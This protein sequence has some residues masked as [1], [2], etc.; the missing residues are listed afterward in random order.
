MAKEEVI[1]RNPLAVKGWKCSLQTD[2]DQE[3]VSIKI[4]DVAKKVGEGDEDYVIKKKVIREKQPIQEVVD[5][6][7]D[8]VGVYNIIKMVTKTGDLS[9]LPRD[10][11]NGLVDT[12]NAPENL[13]ELKEM[14]KQA[15]AAF[16]G[17][18][19]ELVKGLDM[20]SFVE[21][22]TQDQFDAFIKAVADRSS[23]KG[24]NKDE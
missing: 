17:L 24:E 9:L 21:T 11:G 2:F 20:K 1:D 13:M 16:N 15:E 8:S 23:G 22:M 6:D 4:V 19:Q 14:G 10:S 12:T 18:P 3:Y 7:A 5:A